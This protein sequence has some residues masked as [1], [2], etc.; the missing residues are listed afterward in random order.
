[1]LSINEIKEYLK[2]NLKPSRYEHTLGVAETAKKLAKL[3][4]VDEK[5]AEVAGLS[6]DVAKNLS[7]EEMLKIIKENNIKL[8]LVEE[9]NM[10]LWHSIIAPIVAKGKLNIYD[11][12]IL[13]S[14][15]WH[16]TGKENMSKL[17]KIIY[18]ADMIEPSRSFEGLEEI[19]K[20]TFE[21]LDKGVYVG[22]THSIRFLVDKDLLLDE[23]TIKARN[24][25]KVYGNFN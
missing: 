23:N 6:H 4:N 8:S 5:K 12:E 19:R 1:M 17:E 22:L 9:N 10:N 16:T 24:Y 7:K 2:E 18:I 3:N 14:L 25:L 20:A 13:E 11:E 15:R 21:N